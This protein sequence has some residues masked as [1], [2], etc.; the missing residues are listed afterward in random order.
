MPSVKRGIVM[1]GN[2]ER[3]RIDRRRVIAGDI[4]GGEGVIAGRGGLDDDAIIING[5]GVQQVSRG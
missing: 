3:P 4:A 2:R 1:R 5:S